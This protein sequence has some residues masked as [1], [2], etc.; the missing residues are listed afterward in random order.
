VTED[1]LIEW[2]LADGVSSDLALLSRVNA[3]QELEN[4]EPV[5]AIAKALNAVDWNRLLLAGSI[6]ARSEARPPREAALLIAT[7]SMTLAQRGPTRDAAALLFE[8][9]SNKLAVGLAQRRGEVGVDLAARLG[10]GARLELTR[11]RLMNSVVLE[12]DGG[13]LEVNAFQ[14]FLDGLAGRTRLDV[15]VGADR[16][17]E[18]VSGAAVAAGPNAGEASPDGGIPRSDPR[19]R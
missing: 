9:L 13:L 10:V 11:N 2:L 19:A 12:A 18:D 8:Q 5:E 7:S 16:V 17:R 14:Q 15:R 1:D 4:V 6:L 3:L